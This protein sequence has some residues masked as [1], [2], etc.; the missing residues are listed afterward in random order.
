MSDWQQEYEDAIAE[1]NGLI[2]EVRRLQA[3]N[4]LLYAELQKFEWIQDEWDGDT[5]CPRCDQCKIYGHAD[6]CTL[7]QALDAAR[8][9]EV[10]RG[11]V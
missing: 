2:V 7:K 9:Q 8:P 1:R 11:K 10:A 3:V 4:D 6:D 5:F